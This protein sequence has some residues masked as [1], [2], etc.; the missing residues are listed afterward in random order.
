MCKCQYGKTDSV[1]K[2]EPLFRVGDVC[3]RPDKPGSSYTVLLISDR[4][5]V[6]KNERGDLLLCHLDGYCAVG[7]K[8]LPPKRTK[9]VIRC[10]GLRPCTQHTINCDPIRK[11]F[12]TAR[13]YTM[14]QEVTFEVPT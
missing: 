10:I 12:W 7:F 11:D 5:M 14:W 13:G 8:I 6:I 1:C 4:E 9:T 3:T 2:C